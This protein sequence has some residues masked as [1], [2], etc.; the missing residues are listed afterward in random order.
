MGRHAWENIH[1][2]SMHIF[3]A[4]NRWKHI[5]YIGEEFWKDSRRSQMSNNDEPKY[6]HLLVRQWNTNNKLLP[7]TCRICS[8]AWILGC[9]E[10]LPFRI[11]H[12]IS[13]IL[14][15]N[16]LEISLLVPV[17]KTSCSQCRE[18]GFKP[19]SKELDPILQL[20]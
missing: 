2:R 10:A 3:H 11:Q 19:W 7:T 9:K 1:A 13:F 6:V 5:Q 17:V 16:I 12:L 18:S 15:S 20:K 4:R 8:R 14:R